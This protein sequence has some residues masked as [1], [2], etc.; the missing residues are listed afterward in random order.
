MLYTTIKDTLTN[1]VKRVAN[2]TRGRRVRKYPL[3]TPLDLSK[4]RHPSN[5]RPLHRQQ[6][7]VESQSYRVV[8]FRV[9]SQN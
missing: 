2:R 5:A 8:A 1:A 9:E 7:P 4:A 6:A 3:P